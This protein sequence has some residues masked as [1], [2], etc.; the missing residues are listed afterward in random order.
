M[1]K[2][3]QEKKILDYRKLNLKCTKD[4]LGHYVLRAVY[5]TFV[6]LHLCLYLFVA[7]VVFR[8]VIVDVRNEWTAN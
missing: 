1:H 4:S 2:I 6:F 5:V 3:T 7:I 8:F